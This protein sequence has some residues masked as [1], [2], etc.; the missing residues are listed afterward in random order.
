[1][2]QAE[3]FVIPS[4]ALADQENSAVLENPGP[5]AYKSNPSAVSTLLGDTPYN[6]GAPGK[7]SV[8]RHVHVQP[9]LHV[10]NGAEPSSR[11]HLT[12]PPPAVDTTSI[13]V[14]RVSEDFSPEFEPIMEVP[15]TYQ[16]AHH[17]RVSLA[18]R[19]GSTVNTTSDTLVL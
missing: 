2:H 8:G 10:T 3:P 18:S 9:P 6:N 7:A 19:Q 16:S 11:C 4:G 12:R 15:P 5:V 17:R 13:G 1:M 14:T